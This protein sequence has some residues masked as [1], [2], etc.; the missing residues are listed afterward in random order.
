ME[1]MDGCVRG[2]VDGWVDGQT[3]RGVGELKEWMDGWVGDWLD[4]YAYT[5]FRSIFIFI[6][7]CIGH[8][9]FRHTS[10]YNS[11]PWHFF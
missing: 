1:G 6:F 5:S 10:T 2:W 8:H 4:G 11:H 3:D 9:E 7:M